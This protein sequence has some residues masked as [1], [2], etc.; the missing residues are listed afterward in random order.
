MPGTPQ[1][2]E[3]VIQGHIPQT[4]R[5]EREKVEAP[6]VTYKGAP[7]WKPIDGTSLA[8]AGNSPY[9]VLKVGD[10]YYL[11]FQAVW[12]V[13]KQPGGAVGA[14]RQG[15]QRG[16]RDP[17]ERAPSIPRPTSTCT[18]RIPTT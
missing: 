17:A 2:Q 1:A 10:L 6:T 11:C 3:A 15:A 5:V 13:A 18:T 9:D 12:F 7:E 16:L 8:Y 14:G 4:A